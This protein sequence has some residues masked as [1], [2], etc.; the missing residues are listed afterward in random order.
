MHCSIFIV[1]E[2]NVEGI[3]IRRLKRDFLAFSR[4]LVSRRSHAGTLH[5]V[6][7]APHEEND[8][9]EPN[10]FL[11]SLRGIKLLSL[12]TTNL[13]RIQVIIGVLV[14]GEIRRVIRRVL[15]NFLFLSFFIGF[16]GVAVIPSFALVETAF[17]RGSCR[18]LVTRVV[19][20][21]GIVL[22]VVVPECCLALLTS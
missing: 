6:E 20:L 9:V 7:H 4:L 18:S 13:I 17:V 14:V 5:E 19:L 22:T 11:A 12:W 1:M 15:I 8:D 2:L 3:D 10:P 21:F 16:V